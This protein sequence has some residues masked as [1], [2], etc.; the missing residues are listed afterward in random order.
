MGILTYDDGPSERTPLLLEQLANAKQQA[1]FF[2][3]GKHIHQYPDQ[4]K[5]IVL[6]GHILG[7]HSYDHLYFSKLT[8]IQCLDQIECTET[9]INH[10][11]AQAQ[12]K[13]THKVFRFPYGDK[14]MGLAPWKVPLKRWHVHYREL[15]N[16]LKELGFESPNQVLAKPM[17]PLSPWYR[18]FQNDVDWLWNVDLKDWDPTTPDQSQEI[19]AKIRK[20]SDSPKSTMR[21]YLGHDLNRLPNGEGK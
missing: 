6:Q 5:A 20:E 15:Q 10:I 2:C 1:I 11:Y 21:V 14:G 7:N 17:A 4:A 18:G 8:L 16:A 3:L 9:E 12:V 13:R 19:L